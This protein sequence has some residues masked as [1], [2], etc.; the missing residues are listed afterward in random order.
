MLTKRD[1]LL[2]LRQTTFTGR[3]DELELFRSLL[4]LERPL[5]VDILAICGIGGIASD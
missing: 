4:P 3:T 1:K 5:P 2:K